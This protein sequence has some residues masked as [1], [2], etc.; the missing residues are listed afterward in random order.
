LPAEFRGLVE[1]EKAEIAEFFEQ[2]MRRELLYLLPFV[3][4]RIDLR[5]DEF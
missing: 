4:E 5:R 3:D 2:L 1:A